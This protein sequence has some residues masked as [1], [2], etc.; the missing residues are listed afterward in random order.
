MTRAEQLSARKEDHLR[1]EISDLQEVHS[2]HLL[3]LK[4]FMPIIQVLFIRF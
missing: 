3:Y 1:Q 4:G 2:I